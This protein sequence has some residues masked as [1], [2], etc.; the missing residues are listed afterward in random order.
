MDGIDEDHC[1]ELEYNECENNEYRCADGSCIPEQFW[2]DGQFDC[3]DKTD[4]QT[5]TDFFRDNPYFCPSTSSQFDCD[6]ATS[7]LYGFYCGD[8]QVVQDDVRFDLCY[9][10]RNIMY[11]CELAENIP[12]SYGSMLD[13]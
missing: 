2:L 5:L 3:S 13:T 11:F 7:A 9:N 4:E 6:E 12:M 1:E 8:G 10:Y